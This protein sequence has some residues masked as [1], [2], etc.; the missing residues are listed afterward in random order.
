[1]VIQALFPTRQ[2]L[3]CGKVE[4]WEGGEEAANFPN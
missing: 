1:M 4:L 2:S 3:E